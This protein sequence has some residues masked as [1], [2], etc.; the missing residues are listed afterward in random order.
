MNEPQLYQDVFGHTLV[1]LAEQDERIVG[2][3]PAMPTGCSMTYMM[4]AFP[5]RAFDV[6]IAE[7]H[8]VTFSAG[9]AKEGMIP[10]CNVYSS[11]MQRAYDNVIHDI[12]LLRLPVVLCLDRA[13]LVGEDGPT[14]EPV[15]QLAAFRSLPNFCVY[16][17][18]DRTET[19]A[20]WYRAV[21]SKDQPTA[22]VLTRQNL[23][24]MQGSSKE[25]LKGGY[26][27]EDSKK[28]VPD[29]IIIAS[30]SEVELAVNAKAELA[31]YKLVY[32]K[33]GEDYNSEVEDW[34]SF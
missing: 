27:L 7:G 30:G 9:L 28:E 8:S 12:A 34:K 26:I 24:Q 29:A 32:E 11:F 13:G 18:C 5:K 31:K 33:S 15:E 22:L 2:V 21:T 17:P 6:G 19:A 1:E 25:A 20:A 4:K 10:F 23:S 3:T 14:H 16:R